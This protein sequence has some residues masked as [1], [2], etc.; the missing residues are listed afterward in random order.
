MLVKVGHDAAVQIASELQV[1]ESEDLG[2]AQV[3]VGSHPALGTI[4][5]VINAAGESCYRQS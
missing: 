3:M 2:S 5:L 1:H 4:T